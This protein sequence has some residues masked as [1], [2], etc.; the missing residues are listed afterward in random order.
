[1]ASGKRTKTS[2]KSPEASRFAKKR[3]ADFD[4]LSRV[5]HYEHGCVVRNEA[6]WRAGTLALLGAIVPN[7]AN[8]GTPAAGLGPIVPNEANSADFVRLSLRVLRVSVVKI[9]AKRSQLGNN[10]Q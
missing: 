9:R 1:M 6:N 7:E 3:L 2:G 4:E 8:W 10:C 5:R